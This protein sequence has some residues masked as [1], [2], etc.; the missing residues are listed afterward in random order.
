MLLCT[1]MC[2]PVMLFSPEVALAVEST[3]GGLIVDGGISGTDYEYDSESRILLI[4][5]GTPLSITSNGV[6]ATDYIVVDASVAAVITASNLV[7]DAQYNNTHDN[8]H[9][10]VK[11][12]VG[13]SLSLTIRGSNSFLGS[14][15]YPLSAGIEVPAGASITIDG[16]ASN[17]SLLTVGGNEG[18]GSLGAAGIGGTPGQHGG[19]I[20]INGGKITAIAGRRA[21]GIGGASVNV[22]DGARNGGTTH[23]TGGHIIAYGVAGG[24]GIGGGQAGN[25]GTIIIEGA[26]TTVEAYAESLYGTSYEGAGIGGGYQ[27]NSENVEIKGGAYVKAYSI[28]GAGIGGG[29]TGSAHGTIAITGPNT[30]VEASSLFSA[31]IGGGYNSSSPAGD[32]GTIT[33]SGGA[34][35]IATATDN[36]NTRASAAV[37]GGGSS[38]STGGIAEAISIQP[39]GIHA[40][41]TNGAPI[42]DGGV[43]STPGA[44]FPGLVSVTYLDKD[45]SN[46]VTLHYILTG[47]DTCIKLPDEAWLKNFAPSFSLPNESYSWMSGTDVVGEEGNTFTA[48]AWTFGS[49][50]TLTPN[51]ARFASITDI[52]PKGLSVPTQTD[53]IEITFS[54][55]MKTTVGK[56]EAY[57][58]T[59]GV[60]LGSPVWSNGDKTVRYAFPSALKEDT[61]YTVTLTD[62][63]G[64][65][66][67]EMSVTPY[68]HTFTTDDGTP[69]PEVEAIAPEGALVDPTVATWVVTF[70]NVMNTTGDAGNVEIAG[71]YAQA[72]PTLTNRTWSADKKT[73]SFTLSEIEPLARYFV[74]LTDFESSRE[75]QLVGQPYGS[76]FSTNEAFGTPAVLWKSPAGADV[77]T[78]AS[79]LEIKFNQNIITPGNVQISG[80]VLASNPAWGQ[81]AGKAGHVAYTLSRLAAGTTYTVTLT[82][83]IVEGD[84]VIPDYV[85]TFTT[86]GRTPSGG[87]QQTESGYQPGSNDTNLNVSVFGD[88]G[89]NESGSVSVNAVLSGNTLTLI[90]DAYQWQRLIRQSG[91]GDVLVLDISD[92]LS[93]YA[94]GDSHTA[95]DEMGLFV[96]IEWFAELGMTLLLDVGYIG[97]LEISDTMLGILVERYSGYIEFVVR[98]GSLEFDVRNGDTSINWSNAD[99]PITIGI[100]YE[101]EAAEPVFAIYNLASLAEAQK[102]VYKDGLVYG[103]VFTTGRFEA[104]LT[105]SA[106]VVDAAS[107]AG[108]TYRVIASRLNVRSAPLV[109][110]GN[111]IGR[112]SMNDIIVST[113][114][115]DGWAKITLAGGQTGYCS[116]QYLVAVNRFTTGASVTTTARL[117]LRTGPGTSHVVASVAPVGAT[118]T[119]TGISADGM[120]AS[121]EQN[122]RSL[123]M[124]TGYLR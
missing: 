6:S 42:G 103:E 92:F 87:A 36:S 73:L 121:I 53:A 122:G 79:K 56:I 52:S 17:D 31:G 12:L 43:G 106:D 9:P 110:S 58:G 5:T 11:L 55:P 39:E 21:A 57:D 113:E 66:D 72:T 7:I 118:F 63:A 117:N 22:V 76:S 37:G 26:T 46:P 74:T 16:D 85:W 30:R 32:S 95:V 62:F 96:P 44:R 51:S 2:V 47:T 86:A 120:W 77:P 123:F 14:T 49:V 59:S 71:E 114:I 68:R 27:G 28:D 116:M 88:T 48:L 4:K 119:L 105:A 34:I 99:V 100:P 83:F 94:A 40:F 18:S 81:V 60:I 97:T 107:A 111:I 89:N 3:D 115:V 13:A 84:V 112:L 124:H 109:A 104:V 80:A 82:D 102:V 29:N 70:T 67:E 20:T 69:P 78:A 24:A 64:T 50:V 54:M 8:G 35:V 45:G 65:S 61:L 10:A 25:S 108:T 33:I 19:N 38:T 101:T 23:I 75:K 41:S 90:P 91:T 93:T 15:I 1:A 98:K